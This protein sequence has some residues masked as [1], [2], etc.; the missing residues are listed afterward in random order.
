MSQ[1]QRFLPSGMNCFKERR[2]CSPPFPGFQAACHG[3]KEI[4]AVI[5]LKAMRRPMTIRGPPTRPVFTEPEQ[6]Y[7][8]GICKR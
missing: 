2:E 7:I 4:K 8:A 1:N 3:G 5:L 6:L